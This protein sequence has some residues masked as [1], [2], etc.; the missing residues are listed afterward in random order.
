MG[1]MSRR[2]Y[3]N[4]RRKF[5]SRQGLKALCQD[6]SSLKKKRVG[7][8][9]K[10]SDLRDRIRAISPQRRTTLRYIAHAVGVPASTLKDYYKRGLMVKHNSH[11]KPMLTDANKVARVKWAM[12][13][14]RPKIKSRMYLLPGEDP[15]HRSTQ[16]KCFIKKV[17]FLSAL[18]RP[19]WDDDKADWFDGKIGI[20]NFT[21]VVPATR[22]SRNR[23][24]GKLELRPINVTRPVYK[25]MLIEHVIPAIQA[26]WP[27]NSTRCVV[28]QQDNA[29]PHVPSSDQASLQ[30]NHH[31]N[32]Y[33]EIVA[34]TNQAWHD[35]DPW[36]LEQN[37]LTLQCCFSEVIMSAG[38]NSCMV[39]HIGKTA[40]KRSGLP[41]ETVACD[42]EVFDAGCALMS[43]H[44]LQKVMHDL[45]VETVAE[46]EMI[47]IFS[48]MESLGINDEDVEVGV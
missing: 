45:A 10:Y 44:D 20:W 33:E 36:S 27:V 32:T 30:Q 4:G 13:F 34:A 6:I 22:S 2:V 19:R 12:D 35:V 24:A 38:D 9:Q 31:S 17:M 25:K 43:Q 28:I 7:R 26:K 48:A 1:N 23:P 39:P 5:K 3:D 11:I 46:L 18:A 47:D 42:R 21:Q 16:S 41:P 37:F 40:L 14:V 29:R 15:P 8:K